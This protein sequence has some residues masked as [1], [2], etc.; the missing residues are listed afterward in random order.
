M[1]VINT[2]TFT[3]E[4]NK[5]KA[6]APG[7][8]VVPQ[9]NPLQSWTFAAILDDRRDQGILSWM[10]IRLPGLEGVFPMNRAFFLEC[11][12]CACCCCERQQLKGPVCLPS[13]EQQMSVNCI[14]GNSNSTRA[15]QTQRKPTSAATARSLL[16]KAPV[17]PL[18]R[19]TVTHSMDCCC[20]QGSPSS[21]LAAWPSSV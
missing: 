19:Q 5:G 12:S 6:D 1:I 4:D 3:T 17:H 21:T 2:S 7:L 11:K 10:N 9:F 20:P 18:L 8:A 13:L 15:H 14:H 16:D